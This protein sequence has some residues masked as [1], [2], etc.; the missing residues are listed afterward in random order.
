M[1]QQRG[2]ARL[3]ALGYFDVPEGPPCPCENPLC[4]TVM[5][6]DFF[7]E[8]EW[9]MEAMGFGLKVSFLGFESDEKEG[10]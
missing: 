10:P 8:L 4:Q 3:I 9:Q 7:T 1:D 5:L 6:P 2:Q